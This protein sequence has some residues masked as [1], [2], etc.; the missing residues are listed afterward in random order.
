MLPLK[1]L[2]AV[3]LSELYSTRKSVELPYSYQNILS[4]ILR[5]QL[6]A[7]EYM[8]SSPV[9]LLLLRTG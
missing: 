2:E 9:W 8:F 5:E 3:L 1:S 4:V 7:A 6:A